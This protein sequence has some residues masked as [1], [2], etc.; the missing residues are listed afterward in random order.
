MPSYSMT[1]FPNNVQQQE[2]GAFA[3]ARNLIRLPPRVDAAMPN[4]IRAGN[5]E[6][7][8]DFVNIKQDDGQYATIDLYKWDN[9]WTLR[10]HDFGFTIPSYAT[11]TGI[12]VEFQAHGSLAGK[13]I[14]QTLLLSPPGTVNKGNE[15]DFWPASDTTY[16]RGSGND[17][18]GAGAGAW[19]PA[20]INSNGFSVYFECEN[21][22]YNGLVIGR[23]DY[24][25][26]TVY[27]S[28]P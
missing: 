1:R 26:V 3:A 21:Y 16:V 7:N 10:A 6:W 13:I 17:L 25:K 14:N 5:K 28:T 18:W 11:I 24:I 19:T 20:I 22:E 12:Q 23:V 4:A 9:S 15:N 2:P 27:Y 8:S